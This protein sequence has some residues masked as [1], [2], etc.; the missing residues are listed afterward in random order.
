MKFSSDP[1]E[2]CSQ[3]KF[4]LSKYYGE[5][6]AYTNK[7]H[8]RGIRICQNG[9]IYMGYLKEGTWSEGGLLYIQQNGAFEVDE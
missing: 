9:D 7:P 1:K 3:G 2:N 8:G 6:S 5:W 4:A